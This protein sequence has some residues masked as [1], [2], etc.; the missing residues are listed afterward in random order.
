MHIAARYATHSL[1]AIAFAADIVAGGGEAS[2]SRVPRLVCYGKGVRGQAR[3]LYDPTRCWREHAAEVVDG[4]HLLASIRDPGFVVAR[5][6]YMRQVGLLVWR[7]T[8]WIRSARG[9]PYSVRPGRPRSRIELPFLIVDAAR[10]V[11]PGPLRSGNPGG[12]SPC[13]I[14]IG[15]VIMSPVGDAMANAIMRYLFLSRYVCAHC[16]ISFGIIDF[17]PCRYW[18]AAA[19]AALCVDGV[20]HAADAA[21]TKDRELNRRLRAQPDD[22]R[23][24]AFPCLYET[25]RTICEFKNT[26][27]GLGQISFYKSSM[28]TG[29]GSG[30]CKFL[31]KSNEAA[32]VGESVPIHPLR[33]DAYTRSVG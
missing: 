13:D 12:S 14:N 5:H 1:A 3:G 27:P 6:V 20:S 10:R 32:L 33:A 17:F 11:Y 29:R 24:V 16:L 15:L 8:W 26:I 23:V 31:P 28:Y 2:S 22:D 18:W 4:Q 21:V 19:A 30:L 9:S 7:R 25:C